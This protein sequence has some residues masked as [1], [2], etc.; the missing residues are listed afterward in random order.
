MEE[1]LSPIIKENK[2]INLNEIISL[3]K[4][5]N[6]EELITDYLNE[7]VEYNDD[8]FDK[9][10]GLDKIKDTLI[11]KLNDLKGKEDLKP[12]RL[13]ISENEYIRLLEIL[14]KGENINAENIG[15]LY[16]LTD[17]LL[18]KMSKGRLSYDQQNILDTY[19]YYLKD[20]FED[21]GLSKK[22]DW[23]LNK[24]NKIVAQKQADL[25]KEH[26]NEDIRIKQLKFK[27]KQDSTRG[28]ITSV[29]VLEV[30][31]LLGLLI[32]VLALANN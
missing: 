4:Q 11:L 25:E 17:V 3:I 21:K 14:Y 7:I 6:D 31:I 1:K 15:D 30:T 19:I 12:E 28:A 27:E 10:D 18:L 29:A 5:I 2:I 20:K 32:S 9:I 8:S 26:F 13:F 24:Y 23:I 22:E 16:T